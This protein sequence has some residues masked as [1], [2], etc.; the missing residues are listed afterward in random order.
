MKGQNYIVEFIIMFGIAFI[1][2]STISYLFYNQTEFLSRKIG[3]NQARLLNKATLMSI[4]KSSNCRGCDNIT[5]YQEIPQKIGGINYNV[6]FNKQKIQV[7]LFSDRINSTTYNIN[8]T[9]DFSGNVKS[10]NK[11]IEIKI[12][13][14][15]IQVS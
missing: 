9:F 5:I 6:T 15:I 3:E 14:K 10:N 11:K 2:F 12:N 8:E 13:N 4:I 1:I 7:I